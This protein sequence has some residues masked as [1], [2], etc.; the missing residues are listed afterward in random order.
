MLNILNVS[1]NSI[2]INILMHEGLSTDLSTY[3]TWCV[4][5]ILGV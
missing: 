4:M 5:Y 3:Y 1:Y 2:K